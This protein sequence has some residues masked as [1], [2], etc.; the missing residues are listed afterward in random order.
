VNHETTTPPVRATADARPVAPD[1]GRDALYR[2]IAWRVMPVL[3]LA[4]VLAYLDRVNIGT[5]KLQMVGELGLS[6]T[7][8]GFGAGI[9]FV[10]YFIFEIPSNILLHRFGARR[11]IARIM[12]SWGVVSAAAMFLNSTTAFYV[13]R[14][15][16][17][18]AEAGFFPGIILYLT[19]W[20]PPQRR[21]RM[22]TLFMTATAVSGIIGGPLSGWILSAF[23][24]YH[25]WS[26]W[27]WMYLLEGLPSVLVGLLVLA[28]LPSTPRDAGWLRAAERAMIEQDLAAAQAGAPGADTPQRAQAGAIALFSAIYFLL[29]AGLYGVSFWLPS[30]IRATGIADTF[31]IGCLSA[32]P[33]IV[34]AVTMNLMA[35][36]ADRTRRWGM[37]V[38]TAGVVAGIAFWI[39]AAYAQLAVP[40][41][42][43]LTV[44]CAGILTALPLFW[45]LPT[46]RLDGVAAAAGIALIN[47]VGNLAGFV[48]PFAIGWITDTTHRPGVGVTLLGAAAAIA[49][50]MT[51]AYVARS[52]RRGGGTL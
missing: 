29:L 10:G 13:Q 45:N 33:Y 39:S 12:V 47:S 26:G 38:G 15:L 6:D 1:A 7:A 35:R 36:F 28:V 23:H 14:F 5:A 46:A 51:L 52:Q 27:R 16:L 17:G 42:A 41:L 11:W 49:G 30:L 20:F 32:I 19:Y 25:G 18:V 37:V 31:V 22:T 4:Q 44:A 3:L 34:T 9:F 48:S 21:G 50:A 8:Y 43:A 2:K 24:G 40:A